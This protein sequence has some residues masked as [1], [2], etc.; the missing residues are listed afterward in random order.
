M[1]QCEGFLVFFNCYPG[2]N[3]P[4][5][6]PRGTHSL[7][8]PWGY[9]RSFKPSA[10]SCRQKQLQNGRFAFVYCFLS[11]GIEK[12]CC[13]FF[14]DSRF[15]GALE[16]NLISCK[17]KL[18]GRCPPFNEPLRYPAADWLPGCQAAS[19]DWVKRRPNH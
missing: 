17:S 12:K 11:V 3:M 13:C 19:S 18:S 15:K 9:S 4:G 10:A 8:P 2:V 7:Q 16:S 1:S 14:F 6:G 5:E